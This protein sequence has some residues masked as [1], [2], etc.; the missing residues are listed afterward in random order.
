MGTH[1]H[2][3][4]IANYPRQ[5]SVRPSLQSL[6][7]SS[8]IDPQTGTL[9]TSETRRNRSQ[10]ATMPAPMMSALM[11]PPPTPTVTAT[12]T[13]TSGFSRAASSLATSS[14]YTVPSAVTTTGANQ[15]FATIGSEIRMSPAELNKLSTLDPADMDHHRQTNKS[16][17]AVEL[18]ANALF[19]Q[20]TEPV[21]MLS[22]VEATGSTGRPLQLRQWSSS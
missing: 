8:I 18:K 11:P 16:S 2:V 14:S 9:T 17:N 10:D 21:P 19:H 13:P 12:A 22:T 5:N 20:L 6:T 15:R 3:K 7:Q 1:L 4:S